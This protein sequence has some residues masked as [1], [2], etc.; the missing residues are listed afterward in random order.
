MVPSQILTVTLDGR[1]YVFRF[2]WNQRAM[3]WFYDLSL[4]SG[5]SIQRCKGLCLG[6]DPLRQVRARPESPQGVLTV[7]DTLGQNR[8]PSLTSINGRHRV[9]YFQESGSEFAPVNVPAFVPGLGV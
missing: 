6:A 3:R 4:P 5:L 1:P 7:I 8:E 2:F 9:V